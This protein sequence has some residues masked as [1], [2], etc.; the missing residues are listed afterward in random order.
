MPLTTPPDVKIGVLPWTATT[1]DTL[2]DP[3][4]AQRGTPELSVDG[5][6][7]LR[8]T[9]YLDDEPAQVARLLVQGETAPTPTTG[10]PVAA[11]TIPAGTHPTRLRLRTDTEVIVRPT[12][13]L[14]VR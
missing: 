5:R 8:W 10:Q 14:T 1:W 6:E 7:Y 12:D 13:T 2:A 11:L 3:T 4:T 9:V